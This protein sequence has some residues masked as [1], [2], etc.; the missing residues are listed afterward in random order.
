MSSVR[1]LGRARE[2]LTGW[3][4]EEVFPTGAARGRFAEVSLL[5]LTLHSGR[6]HQIRVHLAD[7]GHA[8]VGDPVYGP[9]PSALRG[10]AVD[11]EL[12][13]FPRQALHAESLRFTHPRTG[14]A[15]EFHAPAP[16]DMA[17]L[18]EK[19]GAGSDRGAKRG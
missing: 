10:Q 19:L 12:V 16:A 2:A 9:K 3:R 15:M 6:T 11:P 18:L 5:R 17:R 8:V 13:G 1:A 7:E 4:V 14:R